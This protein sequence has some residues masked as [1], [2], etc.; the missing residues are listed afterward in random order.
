M[1]GNGG[2]GPFEPTE[3]RSWLD[4]PPPP[5]QFSADQVRY[6]EEQARLSAPA[7]SETPSP[8]PAKRAP[9]EKAPAPKT[10]LSPLLLLGGVAAVAAIAAA[11]GGLGEEEKDSG[12]SCPR[13]SDLCYSFT[14][15]GVRGV[16]ELNCTPES[17]SCPPGTDITTYNSRAA[18]GVSNW[19]VCRCK[20]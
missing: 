12:S 2:Y 20:Y 4:N 9:D 13:Y 19:K 7:P 16:V 3:I 6:L 10:D 17:C 8:T 1:S 15:S 14:K 11:A 18:C 5:L